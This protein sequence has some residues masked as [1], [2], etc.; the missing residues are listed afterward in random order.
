M[1]SVSKEAEGVKRV[2]LTISESMYFQLSAVAEETNMKYVDMIREAISEWVDG[3]Q[4][5]L[6]MEGYKARAEKD[7]AMLE[8]FKHRDREVW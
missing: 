2:N 8:E 7:L 1:R 3:K 6:M 5:E 4:G